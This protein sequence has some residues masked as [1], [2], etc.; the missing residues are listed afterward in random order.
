MMEWIKNIFFVITNPSYWI[1]NYPYNKE[2]DNWLLNAIKTHNFEN[3]TEH[4]VVIDGKILWIANH[5][6]GSFTPYDMELRPSR[7]T[8]YLAHS[9]YMKDYLNLKK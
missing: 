7:R 6:Y 4:S 9:K 8:I 5:P 3:F 1:M 2:F